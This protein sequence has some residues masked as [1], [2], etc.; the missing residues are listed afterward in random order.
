M[1]SRGTNLVEGQGISSG[2]RVD[3]RV[4]TARWGPQERLYRYLPG[5]GYKLGRKFQLDGQGREG[6]VSKEKR[7]RAA[8]KTD[9]LDSIL[10]EGGGGRAKF[11]IFKAAGPFLAERRRSRGTLE[12]LG[13]DGGEVGCSAGRRLA[14]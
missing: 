14:R 10:R 9:V 7:K 4:R 13:G 5:R 3:I 2:Q 11:G 8:P 1:R 12:E 6:L